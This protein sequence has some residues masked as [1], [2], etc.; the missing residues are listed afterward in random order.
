MPVKLV[1][2]RKEMLKFPRNPADYPK[3]QMKSLE[4]RASPGIN[5]V[6]YKAVIQGESK[7]K[8]TTYVQFF[9]ISFNDQKSVIHTEAAKVD[10]RAVYH[11]KPSSKANPVNLK[12]SCPDFRFTWEKELYDHKGL[13]GAYRKYRRVPGST[14]PPRNPEHYIGLCKHVMSLLTAL[15]DSKRV[16]D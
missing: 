5:S 11:A 6:F 9:Q 1:D 12:C 4:S 7:D 14:R 2:V 3:L 15:H 10:D 16:I 13:I 8:Y